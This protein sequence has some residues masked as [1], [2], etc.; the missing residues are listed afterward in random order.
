MKRKGFVL[1]ALVMIITLAFPILIAQADVLIEPNDSFYE[2]NRN[3]CEYLGRNYYAN[4]EE[5]FVTFRTQPDANKEVAVFENGEIFFIQFTY[6]HNG[7]LWG[8]AEFRQG[9]ANLLKSGWIPM[10]QLVPI[11]D[12]NS[13]EADFRREFYAYKGSFD[14]LNEAKEVVFWSW[15]GSGVAEYTMPRENMPEDIEIYIS[16]AYKDEQ[17]REW[18]FIGYMYGRRNQ[19]ICISEPSNKNIPAFNAAPEPELWQRAEDTPLPPPSKGLPLLQMIIILVAVVV[20]VT[21]I[22]IRVLWKKDKGGGTVG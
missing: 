6:N 3:K 4:G 22:L 12:H 20:A 5:G 8:I 15:P 10:D 14:A 7:E 19:W 13:F 2:R 17:G 9:V 11:Y 18:G 1:L 16:S 21:V